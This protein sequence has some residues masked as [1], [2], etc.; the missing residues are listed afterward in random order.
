V[1]IKGADYTA[2]QVVGA[3]FVQSYGGKVFLAELTPNQST[4]GMVKRFNGST[5]HGVK[6]LSGR[7]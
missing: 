1:L 3:E 6:S 2:S 7:S 5:P 4:T